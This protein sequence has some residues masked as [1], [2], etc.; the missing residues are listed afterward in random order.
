MDN[1][2]NNQRR[3]DTT[4]YQHDA[5]NEGHGPSARLEP[6]G[7]AGAAPAGLTNPTNEDAPSDQAEGIK[8]QR[9]TD[10]RDCEAAPANRQSAA[11]RRRFSILRAW[12]TMAGYAL[13]CI[14]A[15]DGAVIY[16]ASRWGMTRA[17]VSLV[18]VEAFAARV[19]ATR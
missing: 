9:K 18:E 15:S 6:L 4:T 2:N 1:N 7:T 11:D 3:A 13:I 8:E 14:A 17:L 16:Q 12:L 19:G 10:S 5:S